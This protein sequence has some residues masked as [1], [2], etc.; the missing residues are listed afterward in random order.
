[1]P[2]SGSEVSHPLIDPLYDGRQ[3]IING[4]KTSIHSIYESIVYTTGQ[5][6]DNDDNE[7]GGGDGGVGAEAYSAIRTSVD[8]DGGNQSKLRAPPLPQRAPPL[9]PPHDPPQDPPQPAWSPPS[10]PVKDQWV[11][12]V[13]ADPQLVQCHR[14]LVQ[15]TSAP[16]EHGLMRVVPVAQTRKPPAKGYPKMV[17]QSQTTQ[18]CMKL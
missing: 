7:D 1:M 13:D 4:S 16:R 11:M 9:G 12:Q 3:S 8:G 2:M 18:T 5:G 14:L 6:D 17:S 10:N 15:G